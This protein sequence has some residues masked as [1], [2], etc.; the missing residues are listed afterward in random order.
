MLRRCCVLVATLTIGVVGVAQS[1]AGTVWATKKSGWLV[2]T[3]Q[4]RTEVT[5]FA[6]DYKRYMSVAKTAMTSTHEVVRLAKAAGF[7]EF[8][9]TA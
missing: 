7:A 8:T 5:R 2:I 6:D 1:N 9:D 4:Q 3:P